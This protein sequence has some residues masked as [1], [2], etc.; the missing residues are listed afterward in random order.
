MLFE[1]LFLVLHLSFSLPSRIGLP[2]KTS[3]ILISDEKHSLYWSLFPKIEVEFSIFG[4]VNITNF[5]VRIMRDREFTSFRYNREFAQRG[6]ALFHI[7]HLIDIQLR[8]LSPNLQ[9]FP[10]FTLSWCFFSVID[11]KHLHYRIHDILSACKSFII[12]RIASLYLCTQKPIP[13]HIIEIKPILVSDLIKHKVYYLLLK[14][15]NI[16]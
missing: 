13:K 2:H 10:W 9:L 16:R 5:W 15:C 6:C 3:V 8:F 7:Y 14:L 12:N 4:C 11:G 1:P